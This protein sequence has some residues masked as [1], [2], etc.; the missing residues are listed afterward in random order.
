MPKVTTVNALDNGLRY[1]I[2]PTSRSSKEVSIRVRV[3]AGVA[4]ETELTPS[5]RIA[6]LDTIL[7]T[8]WKVSTDYQQT[9]FSLDLNEASA[10]DVEQALHSLMQGLEKPIGNTEE[11]KFAQAAETS[12]VDIDQI[13]TQQHLESV[14]YG[15]SIASFDVESVDQNAQNDAQQ[16]KTRHFA[17]HNV[18]IVI[19]GGI[20]PRQT[21]KT[22]QSQFGL[23]RV[24]DEQ[25]EHLPSLDF[26][27]EKTHVEQTLV[28]VATLTHLGGNSDSKLL[29]KEILKAT[30]ANKMLERRIQNT[31]EQQQIEGLVS[32]ENQVL[33]NQN[34][35]SQVRVTGFNETQQELANQ[36]IESEIKR[37]AAS[38]F[39]QAEYEMVVSQVR[40]QLEKQTR[41]HNKE[42]Y[43]R[44]Q[45]DRMVKAI[46]EGT[47]YTDPSYDLDLLN[48]HVA[49]LNEFDISKEFELVWG[50]QSSATL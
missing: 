12:L 34:L 39:K 3:A 23:W 7:G 40:N 18:S 1:V 8:E 16:F 6:V 10:N 47:V 19:A 30:L 36:I 49:H 42:S 14:S 2:L 26:H 50:T 38:G 35:L 11:P 41:L 37:T 15:R 48:F 44:S 21:A 20:T 25:Q 27:V 32:V 28:S 24:L 22:V 46:H 45:A 13:M 4:Q 17:P 9:V 5:A 31:F 33:F 43:T 29:R